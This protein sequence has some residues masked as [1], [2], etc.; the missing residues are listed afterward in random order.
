[1]NL[2]D[3]G[4][5]EARPL[6]VVGKSTFPKSSTPNLSLI[7]LDP[8][9]SL[10][11]TVMPLNEESLLPIYFLPFSFYIL[12][13][14][15]LSLSLGFVFFF[16]HLPF[17]ILGYSR[18]ESS[19]TTWELIESFSP[20][21]QVIPIFG[22][23]C[24]GPSAFAIASVRNPFSLLFNSLFSLLYI[25][26]AGL[27]HVL[28]GELKWVCLILIRYAESILVWKSWFVQGLYKFIQLSN[29][30]CTF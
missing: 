6:Y 11:L 2:I 9:E 3:F 24:L 7:H 30:E 1:M 19:S 26:Q 13:V 17:F 4:A 28:A 29:C 18:V 5:D 15:F 27:Y 14:S 20:T 10:S 8:L 25:A 12:R 21:S 22:F 16:P 23:H